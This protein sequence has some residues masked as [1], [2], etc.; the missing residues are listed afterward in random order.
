MD[1]ITYAYSYL[2]FSDERQE[3]GDSTRR[4]QAWAD[5]IIK[6]EGWTLD[7]S[8]GVLDDRGRS[9]F[10]GK[11]K[12]RGGKLGLFLQ[13]IRDGRVPRGSVLIV[14]D[15]DRL[16][17][18]HP[19]KALDTIREILYAG[20][21]I[22]TTDSHLHG[23][24]DLKD[25]LIL[26]LKIGLA[27]EESRKKSERISQALAA[28]RAK[29]RSGTDA[30]SPGL[31]PDWLEFSQN[32]IRERASACRAVRHI[33][34][35]ASQ[36]HGIT[37]ILQHLDAKHVPAFARPTKRRK[38]IWSRSYV[39]KL[40][41][42]RRLIGEWQPHKMVD[43]KRVPDGEPVI[44]FPVVIDP[45]LFY[46]VQSLRA[47]RPSGGNHRGSDTSNLFT[48]LITG[49][50]LT[51]SSTKRAPNSTVLARAESRGRGKLEGVFPYRPIEEAFLET[52]NEITPADLRPAAA[53]PL[54]ALNAELADVEIRIAKV[55]ARIAKDGPLD[56]LV[57]A[58]TQLQDRKRD[59]RECISRAERLSPAPESLASAQTLD[60]KDP[61]TRR[62]LK[63][64]I[65]QLVERIDLSTED[66][67][68]GKRPMREAEIRI[69][70]KS[71]FERYLRLRWVR[72][73][74]GRGTVKFVIMS[75]GPM[76]T[77]GPL[78]LDGVE[79]F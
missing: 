24:P 60:A 53:S 6:T 15:V 56:A 50:H 55:S 4:Q 28:K 11:N 26:S 35:L 31:V 63:A 75:E 13:A 16:S 68:D 7:T 78:H 25:W 69:E 22:R 59:L 3:K 66:W 62:L 20:V 61:E 23:N 14:E 46:Q 44:A 67:M 27:H 47:G 43:G 42:D 71:G 74:K 2:R 5:S 19:F 73:G 54:P 30:R 52:L 58:A 40:L 65:R 77:D 18:E 36:G 79:L 8:L 33:F 9:G 76:I 39:A 64:K 17:R 21:D 1:P 72:K 34:E 41:T 29:R 10:S 51:Y 70:F 38:G 37:S 57:A 45:K 32:G 48:G 12:A 49:Y